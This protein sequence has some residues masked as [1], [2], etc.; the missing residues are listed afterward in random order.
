MGGGT[1]VVVVV[2]EV[3]VTGAAAATG[4]ALVSLRR[5]AT[6]VVPTSATSAI[7]MAS[8]NRVRRRRRVRRTWRGSTTASPSDVGCLIACCGGRDDCFCNNSPTRP[9]MMMTA[10][11][12]ADLRGRR[13]PP[14]VTDA[15]YPRRVDRTRCTVAQ[16]QRLRGNLDV[17][18]G[19]GG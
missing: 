18:K 12:N 7:A 9:A 17:G 5:I 1:S 4:V 2:V 10:K 19:C 16:L 3:V 13:L 8:A 6:A 11:P 15:R 14:G